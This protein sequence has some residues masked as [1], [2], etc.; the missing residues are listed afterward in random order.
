MDIP[1]IYKLKRSIHKEIGKAQDLIVKEIYSIFDYAVLH[2]GTGIWRCYKGNR[3]SEDIDVYIKKDVR[4]INLLFSNLERKGF[5]IKKKKI[6][7]NALFSVL[8]LNKAVVRFEATFN[9]SEY[10]LKEYETMDGNLIT[11]YALTPEVYIKEKV[12]AYLKRRKVRDLY[13]I[14]F[15]LR[16]VKNRVEIENKIRELISNF[17][18]PDD[19]NNLK[20][21]IFEGIVPNSNKM[22]EY[23]KAY[24]NKNG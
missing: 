3:F 10:I 1:L 9:I 13:D 5:V 21:L 6:T 8:E 11:V 18:L 4:K 24:L 14:F 2:G 7:E 22:I 15:L 16:F 12:D 20:I 17:K 23:I 19:E